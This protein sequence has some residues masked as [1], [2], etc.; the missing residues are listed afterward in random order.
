MLE[1][2]LMPQKQ[3]GK[4][5][6]LTNMSIAELEQYIEDMKAEIKRVE[7]DIA[8]K[9]AVRDAASSIFKS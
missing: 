5:K 3:P 2:D 9:K 7:A 1:E 8:K 6:D 4:L